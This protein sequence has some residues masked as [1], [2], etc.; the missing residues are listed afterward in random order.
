MPRPGHGQEG[1]SKCLGF[2]QDDDSP[3]LPTAGVFPKSKVL[4]DGIGFLKGVERPLGIWK[5][6]YGLEHEE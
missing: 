1:G 6:R 3:S 4:A 5:G 2:G